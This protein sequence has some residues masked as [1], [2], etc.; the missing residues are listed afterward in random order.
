LLIF[1]GEND[2][3]HYGKELL[4]TIKLDLQVLKHWKIAGNLVS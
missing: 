4:K 1:V 2:A 3:G